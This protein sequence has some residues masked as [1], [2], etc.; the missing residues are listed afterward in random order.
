MLSLAFPLWDLINPGISASSLLSND[1]FNRHR[2]ETWSMV[3][4][5][6]LGL[7]WQFFLPIRVGS[8]GGTASTI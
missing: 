4:T 7:G 3:F 6:A 8:K 5:E 1:Q 2:L